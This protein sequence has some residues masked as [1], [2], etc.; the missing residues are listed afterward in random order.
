MASQDVFGKGYGYIA[1]N[2]FAPDTNKQFTCQKVHI[3]PLQGEKKSRMYDDMYNANINDKKEL[4]QG[5]RPPTT[6]GTN[7]GPDPRKMNIQL[8]NDNNTTRNPMIGY[9]V[10]NNL[11]RLKSTVTI[12][13]TGTISEDRFI[14][15][16]LLKQLQTNP[17]SIPSYS[18]Q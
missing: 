6:C 13:P 7:M 16:V 14:D 11:D 5:Y 3:G 18:H 2:M 15:P 9:S 4:L 10:N 17:F 8:K 1:E 12:K